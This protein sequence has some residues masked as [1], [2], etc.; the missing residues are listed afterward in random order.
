MK[1]FISFICGYHNTLYLLDKISNYHLGPCFAMIELWYDVEMVILGDKV[2]VEDDPHF[3]PRIRV[4]YV[5]TIW[6]ALSY[7]WQE[8]NAIIYSNT[9]SIPSLLIW[10]MGKRTI[11]F[12]HDPVFPTK[13]SSRYHIKKY[14]VKFCYRFFSKI[15]VINVY[16]K[17]LLKKEGFGEK[18]VII[19]LVISTDNL[20]LKIKPTNNVL[21]LGHIFP[22]KD[23][24]CILKALQIVIQH[25]PDILIYQV[26]NNADY[27]SPDGEEYKEIVEKLWLYNNMKLLGRRK[28]SLRDLDL[29][30]SI[31][32][33]S[34]LMEWQCLAVYD[35]SLLGN[36]LCLPYMSS[37]LWV[38]DE[39][40][41]YHDLWDYQKLA[42]NIIR[43]IEHP[44]E[45]QKIIKENQRRIVDNH[46][47]DHVKSS[48]QKEFAL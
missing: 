16:E 35:A 34:S 47:Y 15:R 4:R 20:S 1:K 40:V 23:P 8:R 2:K 6:Q 17:E 33:N 24:I 5:Y 7:I 32:V 44:E 36:A 28:E 13:Y 46:N 10:L 39:N 30:T 26:G 25:Y 43:Y 48:I 37:F 27:R 45:K 11:F 22:K 31:Y 3:D 38:L 41:R 42:E 12:S 29:N 21:L 14:F 9:F 18:G 19:P